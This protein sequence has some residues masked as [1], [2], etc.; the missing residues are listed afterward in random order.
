MGRL[1]TLLLRAT[2]CGPPR[3]GQRQAAPHLLAPAH[4]VRIPCCLATPQ[5]NTSERGP[6]LACLPALEASAA[7]VE[8]WQ[9]RTPELR[10]AAPD[11]P[12]TMLFSP[13]PITDR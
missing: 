5:W 2:L 8:P 1:L 10:A 9:T 3:V 12:G 6:S 11:I 7:V 4:R 13:R